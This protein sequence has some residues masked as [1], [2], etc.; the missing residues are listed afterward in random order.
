MIGATSLPVELDRGVITV[1]GLR[2]MGVVPGILGQLSFGITVVLVVACLIALSRNILRGRVFSR[3][4]TRIVAVGGGAGLVGAATSR[5]FDNMLA[6]AAMAQA[7]DGSFDTAVISIEPF[8]FV[9]AAFAVAV[10]GTAFVVG[11]RLQ[12]DTEG[13]V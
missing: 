12:K 1:D 4:N 11:D 2:T 9:L 5:F 7:I 8:T 6:N 3:T 10:V 13:L